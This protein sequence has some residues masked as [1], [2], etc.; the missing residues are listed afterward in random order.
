MNS[1]K[2]TYFNIVVLLL[3]LPNA[4][5]QPSDRIPVKIGRGYD[6]LKGNPLSDGEDPGVKSAQIIKLNFDNSKSTSDGKF[7]IPD[8]IDGIQQSQCSNDDTL[9]E[10]DSMKEYSQKLSEKIKASGSYGGG[11]FSVSFSSSVDYEKIQNSV[12]NEKKTIVTNSTECIFY[13]LSLPQ[14]DMPI[15]TDPF[16]TSVIFSYET[17]NWES[18]I[19]TYG[20]SYVDSV[21]LGGRYTRTY[22]FGQK[23]F[24]SIKTSKLGI[25][26][27]LSLKF[28]A[29]ANKGQCTSGSLTESGKLLEEKEAEIKEKADKIAENRK[30]L[31]KIKAQIIKLDDEINKATDETDLAEKKG[32]KKVKLEEQITLEAEIEKLETERETLL[33]EKKEILDKACVGNGTSSSGKEVGVD[34]SSETED[35]KENKEKLKSI[36]IDLQIKPL[37][38][39]GNS[40]CKFDFILIIHNFYFLSYRDRICVINANFL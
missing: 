36:D 15:Y 20:T 28:G 9:S 34:A 31:E 6:I 1:N 14:V 3:F 25:K 39:R 33:N 40:D 4:K 24:T 2:E 5:F 21:D 35:D 26:A 10:I 13:K 30:E 32:E 12:M 29:S 27:A 18:F 17:N 22:S 38:G 16:L 8:E 11:L 23:D 7:L 37:G 19:N